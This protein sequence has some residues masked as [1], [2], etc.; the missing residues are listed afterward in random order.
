MN[1][2]SC[3]KKIS[4]KT[5]SIMRLKAKEET[6]RVFFICRDCEKSLVVEFDKHGEEK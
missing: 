2:E 5:A 1:C 4:G 3:G 6:F